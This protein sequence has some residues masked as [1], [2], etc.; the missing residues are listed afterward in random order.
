MNRSGSAVRVQWL[1]SSYSSDSANCV[2]VAVLSSDE[3]AMRDSKNPDRATLLYSTTS[4]STF[5][6]AV[7]AGEF[8]R[9]DARR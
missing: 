2:E 5:V 7:R 9:P 3:I 8:D 4:W 1:K 6:A